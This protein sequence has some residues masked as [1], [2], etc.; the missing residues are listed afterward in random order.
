LRSTAASSF[1]PRI[2]SIQLG[3]KNKNPFA[4]EA[5]SMAEAID[6]APGN[7]IG[8]QVRNTQTDKFTKKGI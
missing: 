6:T 1:A 4:I 7:E 8:T 5:A 3:Q 2:D